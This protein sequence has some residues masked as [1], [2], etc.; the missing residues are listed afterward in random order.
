MK[1]YGGID[2]WSHVFLTSSLNGS[3]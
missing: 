1:T 2:V 3:N